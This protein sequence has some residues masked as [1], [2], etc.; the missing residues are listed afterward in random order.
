MEVAARSDRIIGC[1]FLGAITH[2]TLA[3]ASCAIAPRGATWRE[4][5]ADSGCVGML[6]AQ[7]DGKRNKIK[8]TR[9]AMNPERLSC[10]SARID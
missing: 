10:A 4:V 1:H 9:Q 7:G 3:T 6:P 2:P 8:N 5:W